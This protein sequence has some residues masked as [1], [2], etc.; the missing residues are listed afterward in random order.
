MF[1]FRNEPALG[2]VAGNLV[3]SFPVGAEVSAVLRDNDAARVLEVV[4]AG[5]GNRVLEFE[6]SPQ[7]ALMSM[8]LH[9]QNDTVFVR[10]VEYALPDS[11]I[12]SD[13]EGHPSGTIRLHIKRNFSPG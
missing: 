7:S 9:I 1:L 4:D 3:V 13:S 8:E 2:E 10:V 6:Q 12:V 11:R 5:L